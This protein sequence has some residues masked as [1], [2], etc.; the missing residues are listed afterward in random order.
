MQGEELYA[1][2]KLAIDEDMQWKGGFGICGEI[3]CSDEGEFG[4]LVRRNLS[5]PALVRHGRKLKHRDIS[6]H[7]S[8]QTES[9]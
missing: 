7:V 8:H 9:G 1:F 6:S 2:D 5:M 3:P 4:V